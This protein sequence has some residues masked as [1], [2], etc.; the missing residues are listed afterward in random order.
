VMGIFKPDSFLLPLKGERMV[1]HQKKFIPTISP[2]TLIALLFT[3]CSHV[4][5]K[6]GNNRKNSHGCN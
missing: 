6:K 5:I 4:F 3:I 2:L 1:F